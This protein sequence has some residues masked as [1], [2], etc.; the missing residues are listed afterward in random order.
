M[1]HWQDYPNCEQSDLNS[2]GQGY[3]DALM[4]CA[5]VDCGIECAA[6]CD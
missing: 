2:T 4:D 5:C 3:F 6:H 1:A